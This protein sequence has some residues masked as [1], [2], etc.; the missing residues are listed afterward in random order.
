MA[1]GGG[2]A[3]D[4]EAAWGVDGQVQVVVDPADGRTEG[5]ESDASVTGV[6]LYVAELCGL[7]DG[8]IE[9]ESKG[10]LLGDGEDEDARGVSWLRTLL[11]FSEECTGEGDGVVLGVEE[12]VV[13][14]LV[15]PAANGMNHIFNLKFIN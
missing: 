1:I 11:H 3:L 15:E 12:D 13:T 14:E 2:V 5:F 10:V 9:H 4:G 7:V 6:V 8:W